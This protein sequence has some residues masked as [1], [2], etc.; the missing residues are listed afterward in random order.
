MTMQVYSP[1]EERMNIWSHAVGFVLSV[2]AL[3]ALVLQATRHGTVLQLASFTIFGLSL[4]L[5][6]AVSTIYH[7]CSTPERRCRLRVYDH[8]S[9][10]VLIAGTYTPF[11]LIV[12]QGSAGWTLFA[13]SWLMALAGTVMKLSFTGRFRLLS[14][15][16]YVGMGWM[17]LLFLKPLTEGLADEGLAWL[18]AGG[19]AYS[20]GALL[21][22]VRT[23]PF[24]H[25]AF[26]ALVLLG[27]TCHFVAVYYFLL[28]AS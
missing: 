17:I 5:M 18:I 25:A 26:H 10:Y 19:V 11:A 3:V 14:T 16:M 9:I 28:P 13:T 12:V 22:S 2:V 21:Y 24:N 15:L 27:S 4:V 1:V 6:Y 7:G 8:V 23:L 20:V